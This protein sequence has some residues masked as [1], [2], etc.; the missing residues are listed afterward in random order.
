MYLGTQRDQFY[1]D[2]NKMETIKQKILN[3]TADRSFSLRIF[4]TPLNAP[5]MG[6]FPF[7]LP[8]LTFSHLL[9]LP[10]SSDI[11]YKWNVLIDQGYR[12]GCDYIYQYSYP[13]FLYIPLFSSIFHF[14]RLFDTCRDDT[15]FVTPWA[16]Q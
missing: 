16:D 11:T 1:D 9:L 10:L 14:S 12:D 8:S 5:A 4:Y 6:N 3:A 7:L 13:I 15:I 2:P